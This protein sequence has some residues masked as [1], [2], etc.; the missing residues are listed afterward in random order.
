VEVGRG[1]L[2]RV[3]IGS[4]RISRVGFGVEGVKSAFGSLTRV[5]AVWE[6]VGEM[7]AGLV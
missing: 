1:V 2:V 5:V 7:V 4:L 6:S 3:C